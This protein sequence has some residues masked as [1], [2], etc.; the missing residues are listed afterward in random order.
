MSSKDERPRVWIG[1]VT[2]P[3]QD[4]P[5]TRD[6]ML[7]LGMRAIADGDDFAVL[8]LRGGTHLLLLPAEAPVSE[9]ANF[10]LMVDNL[11]AT[12]EELHCLGLAPSTIE[13]GRIHNSFTVTAPSGHSI[14]FN[15]THVSDMPV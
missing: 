13:K 7:K 4:I 2:L 1:H 10:D 9:S 5:G 6:F 15:S 14:T 8:E 3:T 11:E 12:H